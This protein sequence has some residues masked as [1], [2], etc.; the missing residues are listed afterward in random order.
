MYLQPTNTNVFVCTHGIMIRKNG[1][2]SFDLTSSQT[3]FSP[4]SELIIVIALVDISYLDHPN[5]IHLPIPIHRILKVELPNTHLVHGQH[6]LHR[7]WPVLRSRSRFPETF[8]H[9]KEI[10]AR[11]LRT[12]DVSRLRH[13]HRVHRVGR[14]HRS[15]ACH[16]TRWQAPRFKLHE[17]NVVHV[18]SF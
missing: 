7:R 13:F 6:P 17:K 10:I 11:L 14:N 15:V 2:T 5:Y 16:Y 8:Q 3:M 9:Q 1:F 12:T 4:N 18:T